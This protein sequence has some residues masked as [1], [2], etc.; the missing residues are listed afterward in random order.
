MVAAITAGPL[1]WWAAT[2]A[3]PA[4][5]TVTTG[6]SAR[7]VSDLMPM[8]LLASAIRALLETGLTL[9]GSLTSQ[10]ATGALLAA[11]ANNLPVAAAIAPAGTPALWAA[12]LATTIG[13]VLLVTGLG[14]HTDHPADRARR[15]RAAQRPAIQRH[16]T[17]TGP[18]PAR[19][20][21]PRA[22]HH[23]SAPMTVG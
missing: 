19:R 11:T 8:F 23:R 16:R 14:G 1:A 2:A 10:L 4:A 13:P 6:P 3:T 18:R 9:H 7:A 12:I 5:P 20:G 21:H 17:G 22:P 15:Q